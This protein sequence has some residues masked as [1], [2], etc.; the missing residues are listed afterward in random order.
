MSEYTE[1]EQQKNNGD[2]NSKQPK[3]NAFHTTSFV[4][5]VMGIITSTSYAK[6]LTNPFKARLIDTFKTQLC[7]LLR[8]L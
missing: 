1:E 6:N 5:F 4:V 7:A 8:L 2:G 3:Q